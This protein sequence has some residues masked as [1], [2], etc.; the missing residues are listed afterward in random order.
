MWVITAE[1]VAS[2][3]K[4]FCCSCCYYVAIRCSFVYLGHFIWFLGLQQNTKLDNDWHIQFLVTCRNK[5]LFF[6][7]LLTV[8]A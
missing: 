5:I 1:H 2:Y 4:I 3:N 6:K 7:T 8:E